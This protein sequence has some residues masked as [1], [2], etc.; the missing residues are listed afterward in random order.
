M[1]LLYVC[2]NEYF[3]VFLDQFN[4]SLLS[5]TPEIRSAII[6]RKGNA[7]N[8]TT[9]N[10]MKM[11]IAGQANSLETLQICN[12][13]PIRKPRLLKSKD[14]N[15]SSFPEITHPMVRS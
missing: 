14:V 9:D 11:S 10:A 3:V 6:A 4:N 12:N 15:S 5:P 2:L 8:P 1:T 13:T 7:E